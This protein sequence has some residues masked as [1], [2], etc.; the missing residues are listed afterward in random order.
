MNQNKYFNP[1]TDNEVR[2]CGQCRFFV[3][4]PDPRR[5]G[6]TCEA[7]LPFYVDPPSKHTVAT[8]EAGGCLAF[9][10]VGAKQ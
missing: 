2:Y 10:W 7:P 6:D 5:E 1:G 4:E 9:Q 8:E 3:Y